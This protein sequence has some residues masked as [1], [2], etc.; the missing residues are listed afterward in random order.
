[1]M[2]TTWFKISYDNDIFVKINSTHTI[3]FSGDKI[4]HYCTPYIGGIAYDNVELEIWEDEIVDKTV[5]NIK[6][7]Y[8]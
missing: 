4:V 7:Y 5:Y 3:Y 8:L 6:N 2:C 1:M